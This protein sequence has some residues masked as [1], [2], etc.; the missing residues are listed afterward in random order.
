MSLLCW[1]S[2][3]EVDDNKLAQIINEI[4]VPDWIVTLAAEKKSQEN[5]MTQKI[6]MIFMTGHTMKK[7]QKHLKKLFERE[8]V[9]QT[10]HVS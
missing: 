8:I 3:N 10:K 1:E 4:F 5:N 6:T 9:D 7:G 2:E